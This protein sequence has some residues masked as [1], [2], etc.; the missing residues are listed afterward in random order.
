MNIGIV[1]TWFERGAAYVSR[2]FMNVLQE[3]DNVSIYAR[4]GEKYAKGDPTWD[5]LNVKWGKKKSAKMAMIG[6][7]YIDK[8]DFIKWIKLNN[9]EAILFNEQQWFDPLIWCKEMKIKTFAYI[10]YYTEGTIPLFDIYDCLI[11]NTKRHAFAFRNHNNVKYLKWGTDTEI[12]KPS[13]NHNER[14]VFFHSAGMSPFRKGTDI[15]IESY[16]KIKNRSNSK[17]LIH[18]QIS[19][20]N[21]FPNLSDIIDEMIND[22]TLEIIEKTI[23]APGLYYLGDIYVYPSRLDGIGL[24]L[25]EAISSGLACVTINNSPMNEFIERD[26]GRLCDVEYYYS[27]QD[28]YYWPMSVA[29]S[30]SLTQILND[31]VEN[32]YDICLMKY[33]AREYAENELNFSANCQ[34][35]HQIINETIITEINSELID[36]INFYNNAGIKKVLKYFYPLYILNSYLRSK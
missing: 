8:K 4:G 30:N 6:S 5:L 9:I 23:P 7:T 12:Y 32:K 22:N 19:L 26:F 27:R 16:F 33:K 29:D 34:E 21:E 36:K 14:L 11:C 20:K 2:Q 18:S 28:G 1:T 25:M 10:D 3:T 24:T 15:L 17:L 31:F 35:L 13:K